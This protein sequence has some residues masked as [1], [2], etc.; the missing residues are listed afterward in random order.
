MAQDVPPNLRTLGRICQETGATY[1][2]VSRIVADHG[3]E[4]K[5]TLN[6]LRYFD[7]DGVG[8]IVAGLA[9][10]L[11]TP[12]PRVD[13]RGTPDNRNLIAGPPPAVI[14]MTAADGGRR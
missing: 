9:G 10:T 14:R 12:E 3:I 4:A 11:A 13:L 8:R 2:A 6:G 1:Q 5:I 7:N